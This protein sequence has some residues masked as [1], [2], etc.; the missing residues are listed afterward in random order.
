MAAGVK[1]AGGETERHARLKRLALF[2][3]Q[4]QGYSACA[5]EV[6]LPKCRYRADVAAYR[7]TPKKIVSTAIF[8]CKQALCDLRR[9][10]CQSDAARQ[11][12][13]TICKR[14]Q[15]LE[16]RLHVHYPNLRNGDSLF[17]EFDLPDFTVIGHRGYTRLLRDLRSLQ[18]RLY[19]CTKFD[20]L[21][22]Y[23]CANLY[24]LVVPLELFRDS[25]IPVGWGALVEDDGTLSLVRK[26]IWHETTGD[27]HIRLLH[28]IAVAG[29]RVIN[30]NLEITFDDI[31][32]WSRDSRVTRRLGKCG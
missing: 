8:E 12:L 19:D 17:P 16:S 9:D 14:R 11:R 31:V 7:L 4:T 6:S 30:Q 13:E 3:A 1:R 25:E 24:F 2:W 15:L 26:P 23:R 22:R 20:K 18:N 21:L 32:V 29:T 5:M 10:N 27:Y 28:R